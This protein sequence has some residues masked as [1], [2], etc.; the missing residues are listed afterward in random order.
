MLEVVVVFVVVEVDCFGEFLIL[1][2]VW[3]FVVVLCGLKVY[4]E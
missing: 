2:I 1:V 3:M 4:F